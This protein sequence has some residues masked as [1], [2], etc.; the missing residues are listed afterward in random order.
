MTDTETDAL[1]VLSA[2]LRPFVRWLAGGLTVFG[3]AVLSLLLAVRIVVDAE[4]LERRLNNA[5]NEATDGR[6]R[7]EID[8]VRWGLFARSLQIGETTLR[9]DSQALEASEHPFPR[10]IHASISELRLDGLQPWTLIWSR[11]LVLDEV[12][13]RRPHVRIQTET[14][15]DVNDQSPADSSS[16]VRGPLADLRVHRFRVKDGMLTRA[17]RGE[18]L[19]DSLWGLSMRFDSLST[20]SAAG[21][22]PTQYL[23]NRFVESTLEGYRHAVVGMPYVLQLGPGR[24]SR[25]DSLLRAE[26]VQFTPTLSDTTFM[27]RHEY[28]VNR[29]RTRVNRMEATGVD[30]ARFVKTGALHAATVRVDA[31]RL[32]VYRDNHLPERPND[33]PPP[34]PQDVVEAL[35]RSLRIDTLRVRDS[36]IRYTK[37]PEGVPRTGSIWFDDLWASLYNVTNEPGHRTSVTPAVVEARTRVNGTGRL[38]ATFRIPLRAPHLALSFEG[39]LGA[40][41]P[42]ALNETFVPLGGVRIESGEVDSLWFQAD[43]KDG[44]AE[45]SVGGVYRNLEVETLDKATGDRGIGHRFKTVATG[46]ALRSSNLPENGDLET[47][48]IQHEHD[49][50]SSFFKFLWQALRDGIY[51]LVGI[52]RLPR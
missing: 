1:E 35:D 44:V 30:Y 38:H 32:D 4:F 17:Q 21:Q 19:T 6:Y 31:L 23:A 8:A 45:G 25:R 39:R 49:P 11:E 29:V 52:D 40:M 43:V 10:R 2:R 34:M 14:D 7:M 24:V 22:A 37:R 50:T 15:A 51:S 9:P 27:Q 33:P 3:V 13:A 20:D 16:A 28:R 26:E 46:L 18:P 41:D 42:R 5:L 48:Q 47:G 36:R 12:T